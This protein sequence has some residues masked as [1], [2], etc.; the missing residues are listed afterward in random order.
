MPKILIDFVSER[1]RNNIFL[2]KN[3]DDSE[4][5][6]YKYIARAFYDIE[7]DLT[8][9]IKIPKK[10]WPNEYKK[11]KITNLWKY[12]L[13]NGWRI[14]FSLRQDDILILAMILEWLSHK[15]YEK[16]FNY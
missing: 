12:D 3:G 6:L 7:N 5:K 15:E 2:L 4:R 10:L 14:I 13:P 8:C 11:Y 16:R 9:C 1:L